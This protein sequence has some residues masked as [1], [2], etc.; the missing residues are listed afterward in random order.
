M[1][2]ET[3]KMDVV[4]FQEADVLAASP[5]A[6]TK[7]NDGTYGNAG[8]GKHSVAEWIE[9]LNETQ[10]SSDVFFKYNGNEKV[11]AK[12]LTAHE[13]DNSLRDGTYHFNAA[14]HTWVWQHQ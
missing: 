9:I 7:F 14:E 2:M 8:M 10:S 5:L 11:A 1:K 4:R 12:D 13:E 3:P 6:L